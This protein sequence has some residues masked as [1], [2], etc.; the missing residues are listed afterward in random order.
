MANHVVKNPICSFGVTIFH[1]MVV[2]KGYRPEMDKKWPKPLQDILRKGW[3]KVISERPPLDD[4][5]QIIQ[6]EI[7]VLIDANGTQADQVRISLRDKSVAPSKQLARMR[8][9]I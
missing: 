9:T 1:D 4:V 2:E 7:G 5:A 6:H 3:S 8:K